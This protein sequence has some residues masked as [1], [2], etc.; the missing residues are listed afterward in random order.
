[1]GLGQGEL[2]VA[3]V[4]EGAAA[5]DPPRSSAAPAGL[6]HDDALILRSIRKIHLAV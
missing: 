6:R 2:P 3:V 1:M 4:D 5:R